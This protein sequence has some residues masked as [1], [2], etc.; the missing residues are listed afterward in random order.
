MNYRL[1]LK[2]SNKTPDSMS[3]NQ[4]K[5]LR[6]I[7]SVLENESYHPILKDLL[8]GDQSKQKAIIEKMQGRLL[9]ALKKADSSA[10]WAIEGT[11]DS[12]SNRVDKAD[13][14]TT[15]SQGKVEDVIIELD[16]HRAD[17]VA[18]KFLS[19]S[20]LKINQDLIYVALC[21]P[22]TAKMS[23]AECIKY[24]GYCADIANELNEGKNVKKFMG[25]LILDPSER[26]NEKKIERAISKLS[27]S[28]HIDCKAFL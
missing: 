7:E 3:T 21:Y 15:D 14:C 9:N 23:V 17:Q 25:Y 24:F 22:G 1:V 10:S 8:Q 12:S 18:K 5:R 11:V 28:D 4:R 6:A 2:L 16:K 26:G 13:V 19:R 20:A 27:G